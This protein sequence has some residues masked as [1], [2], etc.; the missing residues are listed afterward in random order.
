MRCLGISWASNFR[1]RAYAL[2]FPLFVVLVSAVS[3]ASAVCG[4]SGKSC[5][6]NM[7][8]NDRLCCP[9]FVCGPLGNVCQPGCRIGGVA[10]QA[11]ATD[12]ASSCRS[13]QPSRST[14]TW[15]TASNGSTCNDGNKCT[16]TDR[17]QSGSCIGSNPVVCTALDACHSAGSC[18]PA[19][20]R[21]SNPLKSD[22]TPCDDLDLCNGADLC[23][24]G[25]CS[26]IGPPVS[27][28]APA[29]CHTQGTC[30]PPTGQCSDP[31]APDG[32]R[33]D[34]FDRPRLPGR[35]VR[36]HASW[37]ALRTR[38]PRGLLQSGLLLQRR[39][40]LPL[41]TGGARQGSPGVAVELNVRRLAKREHL[42]C[43][44]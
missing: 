2:L 12:P 31:T 25:A 41:M 11:G 30:D 33:C 22:G 15:T 38:E 5:G 4:V 24:G 14:S 42:P 29:P 18:A 39:G 13:C 26:P 32:T 10:Y 36:V 37:R 16:Q 43:V 3:P 23:S 27:C 40:H 34:L 8:A 44:P 21:C 20:G 1:V 6:V 28:P 35:Y 19:T 17:C 9:G 7:A